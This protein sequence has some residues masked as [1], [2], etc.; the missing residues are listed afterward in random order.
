M[1]GKTHLLIA[2]LLSILYILGTI[3]L[4]PDLSPTEFFIL[5]CPASMFVMTF[6]GALLP[7]ID[8]A[9]GI[10]QHRSLITHSLIIPL[11]IYICI[12]CGFEA[13]EVY[14]PFFLGFS[15]HLFSDMFPYSRKWKTWRTRFFAFKAPTILRIPGGWVISPHISQGIL[16][17]S[18]G[19]CMFAILPPQIFL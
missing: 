9:I 19:F 3:W 13:H 11:L 6:A 8:L 7:D 5:L 16:L 10:R 1:N 2:F 4:H 17:L 15:S 18:A 14:Q 12:L